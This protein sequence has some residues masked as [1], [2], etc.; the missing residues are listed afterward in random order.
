MAG[1]ERCSATLVSSVVLLGGAMAS[2]SYL[3]RDRTLKYC[4]QYRKHVKC[5]LLARLPLVKAAEVTLARAPMRRA[6]GG[7]ID[8]DREKCHCSHSK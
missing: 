3:H 2:L 8:G 5:Y 6:K 1:E 4:K 7:S